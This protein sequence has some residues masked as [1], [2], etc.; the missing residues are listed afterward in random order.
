ML[1]LEPSRP[2]PLR[3]G[4]TSLTGPILEDSMVKGRNGERHVGAG[5]AE[6]FERL[7]GLPYSKL[8]GQ[9]TLFSTQVD[10]TEKSCVERWLCPPR[11]AN[12]C[13]HDLAATLAETVP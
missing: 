4:A 6:K 13:V 11:P 1:T 8:Q 10:P 9:V 3:L 5:G 7:K 12:A 2:C